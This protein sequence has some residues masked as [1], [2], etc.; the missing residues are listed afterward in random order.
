MAFALDRLA[1]TVSNRII[2]LSAAPTS[3]PASYIQQAGT[4]E[5]IVPFCFLSAKTIFRQGGDYDESARTV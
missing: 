3:R 4:M 2:R 1:A 5:G